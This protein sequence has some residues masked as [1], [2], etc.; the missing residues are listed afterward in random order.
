MCKDK[1]FDHKE[2]LLGYLRYSAS[3]VVV[4]AFK[5]GHNAKLSEEK[6]YF[7]TKLAKVR[8]KSTKSMF[9]TFEWSSA[10]NL[11]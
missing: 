6:K 10:R 1:Y 7:N 8:I 5:N 11:R 3:L 2:Y 4:S 9:S